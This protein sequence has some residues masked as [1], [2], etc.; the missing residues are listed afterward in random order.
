M[1]VAAGEGAFIVEKLV[2]ATGEPARVKGAGRMLAE[3]ALSDIMKNLNET[4]ASPVEVVLKSVDL[5]RI[6]DIRPPAGGFQALSVVAAA[7]S[8]D[9]LLML[10]DADAIALMV[11]ALFGADPE[12]PFIPIER[13]LS[14]TEMEI[15]DMTFR[16]FALAANGSGQRSLDIRLPLRPSVTG[17]ELQKQVLRDG[18]A[19]RIV[20]V[21]SNGSGSGTLELYMPQRVLLKH[22]A[23]A[24][25]PGEKVSSDEWSARFNKEIKRSSVRLD[26]IIPLDQMTLSAIATLQPGQII[27]VPENAP[28]ETRLRARDKT[29]FVCEFGKLG[30]NYTVRVKRAYD[31]NR[32]IIEGLLPG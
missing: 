23:G 27:P 13:E 21:I 5:A 6:A 24:G 7:A 14:P 31:E 3:R 16:T 11:G 10:L 32:E 12:M 15:A 4:L 8:A 26:A 2:G 17:A 20:F 1:S 22:R 18:P 25:D 29:L 9:A 19:V 30:Q 28:G